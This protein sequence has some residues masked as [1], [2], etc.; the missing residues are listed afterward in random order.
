MQRVLRALH[1][2]IQLHPLAYAVSFHLYGR[3]R[4]RNHDYQ[5]A[6]LFLELAQQAY[7]VIGDLD[8]V[9]RVAV[10]YAGALYRLRQYEKAIHVAQEGAAIFRQQEPK[11]SH[12]VYGHSQCLLTIGS[13][14]AELYQRDLVQQA[15]QEAWQLWEQCDHSDRFIEQLGLLVNQA[16]DAEELFGDLVQAQQLQ[17]QAQQLLERFD[18]QPESNDE[19]EIAPKRRALAMGQA[20]VALRMQHLYQARQSTARA[21]AYSDGA[22]DDPDLHLLNLHL[23][24]AEQQYQQARADLLLAEQQYQQARA[25]LGQYQS[26]HPS[27]EQPSLLRYKAAFLWVRACLAQPLDAAKLFAQAE[28]CYAENNMALAATFVAVDR[29]VRLASYGWNS[30]CQRAYQHAYNKLAEHQLTQSAYADQLLIAQA[31]YDPSFPLEQIGQHAQQFF[32]LGKYQAACQLWARFATRATQR[33]HMISSYRY[34]AAAI[35]RQRANLILGDHAAQ[36]IADHRHVLESFFALIVEDHPSEAFAVSEQIHAGTLLDQI[37]GNRMYALLERDTS[38]LAMQVRQARNTLD[39]ALIQQR[40]TASDRLTKEA[41]SQ[42]TPADAAQQILQ[43]QQQFAE[44]WATYVAMH[45]AEAWTTGRLATEE[46]IRGLLEPGSVLI[47]YVRHQNPVHAD[48]YA[49]WAIVLPY[50]APTMVLPLL[51]KSELNRLLE[52]WQLG[53]P[54]LSGT[55]QSPEARETADEL[56]E[57]LGER[58]LQPIWPQTR[59][60]QQI[61]YILDETL[62]AFPLHA[63]RIDQHYLVEQHQVSYIPSASFW[64]YCHRRE[65]TRQTQPAQVLVAGWAGNPLNRLEHVDQELT[66]VADLLNT[67]ADH[68][69]HQRVDL[70]Q[71]MEQSHLIH[72]ACHGN[73]PDDP[74]TPPRF[75]WLDVGSEPLRAYDLETVQL[76]ADLLTLSACDGARSGVGL[77]GLVSAALVAGASSVLASL[78]PAD[79]R[80]T[81]QLMPQ[82]YLQLLAGQSRTAALQYAQRQ[83]ILNGD[84][85]ATWAGF[86][87]VGLTGRLKSL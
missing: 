6:A 79:D 13:A 15:Y 37:A 35:E 73:F 70:L 44:A 42:R 52:D 71:R 7:R 18:Q 8:G 72:L 39:L 63:A 59:Q 78:W 9:G 57:L 48:D 14:A 36:H 12:T 27:L 49:L 51:K 22:A 68:G 26:A 10:H 84:P 64:W 2:I 82:F 58:L 19:V 1:G 4:F 38:A 86:I 65:Q 32:Q 24:L 29:V 67:T 16:R 83:R 5:Q 21:K 56:L 30:D 54:D 74:Q 20:W 41:F 33:D 60:Y 31:C 69:P 25:D 61:L 62:P 47:S 53:L 23:L 17:Q 3:L 66:Q 43:A 34:A 81:S 50:D 45:Q 55:N 75:A 85:P 40:T 77:Q 11:Q 28:A 87:L 76:C 80:E 46:D